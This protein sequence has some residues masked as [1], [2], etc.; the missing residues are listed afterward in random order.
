MNG[1]AKICIYNIVFFFHIL[2]ASISCVHSE[3]IMG[4]FSTLSTI[5]LS[6]VQNGFI[7]SDG[8]ILINISSRFSKK[9]VVHNNLFLYATI[10]CTKNTPKENEHLQYF[11]IMCH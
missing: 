1:N 7:R 9:I 11:D 10:P 5:C 8:P 4:D 6:F 2:V 3:I